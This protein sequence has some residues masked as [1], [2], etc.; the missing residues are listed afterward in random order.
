MP[1]CK[2]HHNDILHFASLYRA[3]RQI[4]DPSIHYGQQLD[5]VLGKERQQ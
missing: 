3:I 4:D 1:T 5:E 2:N